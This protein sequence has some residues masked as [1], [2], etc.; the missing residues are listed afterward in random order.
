MYMRDKNG[1]HASQ[2]VARKFFNGDLLGKVDCNTS[3]EIDDGGRIYMTLYGTRIAYAVSGRLYLLS[4]FAQSGSALTK[5]RQRALVA[6]AHE[7]GLTVKD[8]KSPN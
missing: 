5:A 2:R 3:C 7:L 8:N 1:E 4:G 6:R